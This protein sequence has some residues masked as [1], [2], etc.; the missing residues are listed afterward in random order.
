MRSS[1]A[2]ATAPARVKTSGARLYDVSER[3]TSWLP[4]WS[5]ARW[6]SSASG[7]TERVSP[8]I[9]RSHSMNSAA[10]TTSAP[11]ASEPVRMSL[12]SHSARTSRK[13]ANGIQRK[14]AYVGCTTA[15]TN[16]AALVEATRPRDGERIVSSASASAAG[17]SSWREEVA[18]S[19]RKTYEPPIPGAKQIMATCAPA[20]APAAQPRRNRAQPI[21]NATSTAIG[22]RID[23]RCVTTRSGSSPA[24]FAMSAMKPCHSGSA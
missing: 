23:G 7:E 22:A 2:I 16:A 15:S 1:A 21:S 18:G 5:K 8:T 20:V 12:R 13:P 9:G 11:S 17:T 4:Y 6:S 3:T 19:E 10:G 14:M 24:I